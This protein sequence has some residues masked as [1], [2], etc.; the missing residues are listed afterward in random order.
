MFLDR[1]DALRNATWVSFFTH[2]T[3]ANQ[4][5]ERVFE[6]TL[7][8]SAYCRT[9]IGSMAPKRRQDG[10]FTVETRHITVDDVHVFRPEVA[11]VEIGGTGY[12]VEAWWGGN[13]I[14]G[15]TLLR[16]VRLIG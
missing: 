2:G 7:V 15:R 11:H 13:N 16:T 8:G 1:Q 12:K 5:G 10:T 6:D 3:G 4:Y 9:E 14:T